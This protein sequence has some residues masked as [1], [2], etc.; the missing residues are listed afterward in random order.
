[1]YHTQAY[2]LG[3]SI[4]ALSSS[5]IFVIFHIRNEVESISVSH[6]LLV[7]MV[8]AMVERLRQATHE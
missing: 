2:E 6:F 1:M 7:F 5:R 8:R 4:V 3:G